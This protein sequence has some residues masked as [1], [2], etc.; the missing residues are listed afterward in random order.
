M[1]QIFWQAINMNK[2][3]EKDIFYG[4]LFIIFLLENIYKCK[5]IKLFFILC[6][7]F[8]THVLFKLQFN[9]F[10]QVSTI[11]MHQAWHQW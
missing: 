3:L 7:R 6:K 10:F 2:I 4:K 5:K 8:H 9:M 11:T 1:V